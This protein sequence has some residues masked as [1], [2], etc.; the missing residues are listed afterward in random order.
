MEI[1]ACKF[2]R[3]GYTS[4]PYTSRIHYQKQNKDVVIAELIMFRLKKEDNRYIWKY[5]LDTT[6]LSTLELCLNYILLPKNRKIMHWDYSIF[7][8]EDLERATL[9]SFLGDQK[10]SLKLKEYFY[11]DFGV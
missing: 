5:Y 10:V 7:K 11:G 2:R 4:Y 1:K 6:Y 3:C 8:E 9:K